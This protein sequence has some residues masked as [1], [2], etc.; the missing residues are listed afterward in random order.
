MSA[1]AVLAV[2]LLSCS[3]VPEKAAARIEAA[4][5]AREQALAHDRARAA[6]L[7]ADQT[8]LESIPL[9]SK[10]VYMSIHTRA[11]WP[12]PFIVVTKSTVSL[13]VLYP[14]SG[15]AHA[16]GDTFLRPVAARRQRL[17]LRPSDLPDALTALPE[18][19]WPYGRV[20]AV[21]DDPTAPRADSPQV[22]RNEEA[23]M[24][25]LSDL[26]VVAYEW[27]SNGR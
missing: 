9:P 19:V 27:P 18:D 13:S 16:P 26:G 14:S 3:R 4:A 2:S 22:R 20:I 5:Q 6:A 17:E 15:P 11:S 23:T 24:K 25:T 1:A 8:Q 7:Q 10:N 12:N 21:E